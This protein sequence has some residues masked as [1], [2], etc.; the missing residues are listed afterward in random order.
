LY[1]FAGSEDMIVVCVGGVVGGEGGCCV[2][3]GREGGEVRGKMET[4]M[5]LR[6][7]RG[8]SLAARVFSEGQLPP[9]H[10]TYPLQSAQPFLES[11]LRATLLVKVMSIVLSINRGRHV[12]G[13]VLEAIL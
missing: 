4:N 9:I 8:Q 11:S 5:R 1:C 3:G 6:W 2:E 7:R 10:S 12:V 13:V